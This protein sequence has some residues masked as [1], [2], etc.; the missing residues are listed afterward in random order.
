[1]EKKRCGTW[2]KQKQNIWQGLTWFLYTCTQ[3]LMQNMRMWIKNSH[4]KTYSL[5]INNINK[6]DIDSHKNDPIEFNIFM[7]CNF[8]GKMACMHTLKTLIL[9]ILEVNIG[10]A[11]EIFSNLLTQDLFSRKIIQRKQ[12]QRF[13]KPSTQGYSSRYYFHSKT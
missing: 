11:V 2:K 9:Y 12:L 5:S 6:I 4:C 10:T 3:V 1:M 8:R 13:S 7:S